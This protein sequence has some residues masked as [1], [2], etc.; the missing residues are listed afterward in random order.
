MSSLPRFDLPEFTQGR[1][2]QGGCC[3]IS[4]CTSV[5]LS[6]VMLSGVEA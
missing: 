5:M 2:R 6:P 3:M 4:T 1:L